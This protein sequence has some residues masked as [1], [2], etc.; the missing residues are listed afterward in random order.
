MAERPTEMDEF[1]ND[2]GRMVRVC[3]VRPN[4][5]AHVVPLCYK[6]YPEEGSFFLSTGADSVTVK[7]LQKNPAITLCIDD[8]EP[9][10]RCVTV[11]G[12][13]EVSEVMGTDHE[14]I[15][16]IIDQFFGPEMWEKYKE[17]PTAQKI[18]VRITL[19]PKKWVWWDHRRKLQGSA[20]AS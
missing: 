5:T 13:A 9:P 12:D 10:F 3:T 1:L 11:E 7:N 19:N 16:R 8:P 6:F 2:R 15:K 20:K 4:G 14:G 18:R 17:T